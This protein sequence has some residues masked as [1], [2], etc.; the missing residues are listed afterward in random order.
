LHKSII[1]TFRALSYDKKAMKNDQNLCIRNWS[2]K[3][4]R[5]LNQVL[6]NGEKA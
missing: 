1:L 4:K 2:V 3:C 5:M 6:K